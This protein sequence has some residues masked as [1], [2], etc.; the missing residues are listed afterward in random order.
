LKYQSRARTVSAASGE[1]FSAAIAFCTYV[2]ARAR[3]P[4]IVARFGHRPI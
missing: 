2:P 1:A 4:V 3:S